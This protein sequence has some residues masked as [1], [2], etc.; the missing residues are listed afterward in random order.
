M[1]PVATVALTVT[2]MQGDQPPMPAR[3]PLV[4]DLEQALGHDAVVWAPEDLLVYEYDGTFDRGYPDAVAF[5]DGVDQ[6]AETIRIANRYGVPITPR[7]AGTGLS[8]GALAVKGGVLLSLNRMRRILEIDPENR[9]ALVEPGVVNMD[10]T[11]A[12]LPHGLVYMPDPSSQK[13][14]TIGG[15]VAE[16]AGGPHCL[17]YGATTNHVLGLEVVTPDGAVQ[18]IGGAD[19]ERPGYDLVG[20]VV[21]SEGTLGVVTKVRVRLMPEPQAV[22]TFLAIFDSVR[23]AS[24]T[25]SAIV[26][27]GIIPAALEM[28]DRLTIAAV[29]PVLHTGFPLDAEAVLIVEVDG[30]ALQ[31][32]AEGDTVEQILRSFEPREI[33]VATETAEREKLW[34]GRKGAI[35]ALGHIQPNYYILDGVVPR[36]KLP[37]VLDEVYRIIDRYD[38]QVANVFHAGDGNLHPCIL[39]DERIPGMGERVLDAGGEIMRLCVDAGGAITGEHGVG[40]E[41]RSYLPWIFSDD[42]IAAMMKLKGAFASDENFNPCK[43]FATGHGCGEAGPQAQKI[44]ARFGSDAYV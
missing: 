15:N 40:L 37:D 29:E 14:C 39:F 7:G 30:P 35:S 25:V 22:R 27:A 33:R 13:V 1:P 21:G 6:V 24:S 19:R 26:K 3:T 42:D 17:A 38:L 8:G 2:L 11:V 18:W 23:Q 16:N 31:V 44:I 34:A 32:E 12:A 43:I 5:P 28:I 4:R 36:T 20:C 9:T 10:L 41:K